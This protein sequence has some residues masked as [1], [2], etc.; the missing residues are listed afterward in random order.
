[1]AGVKMQLYWHFTA[2]SYAPLQTIPESRIYLSNDTADL[3]VRDFLKFSQGRILADERK[4]DAG[5]I[6]RPGEIYR[7]IRLDSDFGRMQLLVT[8]GHLPY[9][10]GHEIRGYQVS[11]LAATLDKAGTVGAKLLF[12]PFEATDRSSAVLQFPGGYIAEVHSLKGRSPRD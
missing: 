10:F 1:M 3:F 9:P 7:R 4:A 6:G 11:D 12:G 5:E 2:P 8:N